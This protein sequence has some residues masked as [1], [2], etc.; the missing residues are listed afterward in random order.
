MT[1]GAPG[2]PAI[3]RTNVVPRPGSLTGLPGGNGGGSTPPFIVHEDTVPDRAI[4]V[5]RPGRAPSPPPA[6]SRA[7]V[8]DGDLERASGSRV[9]HA[10]ARTTSHQSPPHVRA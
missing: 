10:L 9:L 8:H 6:L 2:G 7:D 1:V 4:R 5:R 3:S